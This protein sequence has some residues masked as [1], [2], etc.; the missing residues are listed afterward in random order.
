MPKLACALALADV[1]KLTRSA[2]PPIEHR[3]ERRLGFACG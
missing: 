3:H 2:P 1:A